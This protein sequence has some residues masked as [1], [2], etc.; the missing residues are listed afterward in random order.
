MLSNIRVKV[1]MAEEGGPECGAGAV[2]RKPFPE[3][4]NGVETQIKLG[5]EHGSAY[6]R[7]C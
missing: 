3:G 5:R 2:L 6:S 7:K 1:K 4:G